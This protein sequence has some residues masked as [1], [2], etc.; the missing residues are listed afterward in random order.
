MIGP[1]AWSWRFCPGR[2]CE[3]A[4]ESWRCA[5]CQGRSSPGIVISGPLT[6]S[7]GKVIRAAGSPE[8]QPGGPRPG[9]ARLRRT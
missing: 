8:R 6:G 1:A 9:R 5:T 7:P 3:L 4:R 2:R